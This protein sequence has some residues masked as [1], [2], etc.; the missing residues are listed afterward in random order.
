MYLSDATTGGTWTSSAAAYVSVGSA[1]GQ[2]TGVA[3]GSATITYTVPFIYTST[4]IDTN[5]CY[6][7]APITAM[8]CPMPHG[9]TTGVANDASVLQVYT[10]FPNPSTGNIT[11]TQSVAVDETM[12]V[13]V[14]NQV[15]AVV[16]TGAMNFETG[17]A[18]MNMND[19][20]PGI[21]LI[22]LQDK[23]GTTQTFK[24]LIEK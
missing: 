22:L 8:V 5:L 18:Q 1:T 20:V 2:L 19:V 4:R 21:Y 15:G 23:K 10:L 24:V 11:I 17:K 7:T 9:S 3:A 12:Q 6:V 13:S 16:Y 14:M